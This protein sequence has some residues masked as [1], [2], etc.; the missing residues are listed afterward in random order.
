MNAF[1]IE[2][3]NKMKKL[4]TRRINAPRNTGGD[5]IVYRGK[6]VSKQSA[7]SC[8]ASSV[9]YI[10]CNFDSC[11]HVCVFKGQCNDKVIL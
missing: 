2:I 8:V 6:E 4:I 3:L 1:Q 10:N 11:V 7:S 5:I 9:A